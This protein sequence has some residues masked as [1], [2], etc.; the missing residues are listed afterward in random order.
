MAKVN[1]KFIK[2]MQQ[3]LDENDHKPGWKDE[4]PQELLYLLTE[5][6]EELRH[7]ILFQGADDIVRECADVANFAMMI[8]DV[9]LPSKNQH[10]IKTNR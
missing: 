7:A 9:I 4:D 6:V 5:E 2:A 3:K 8:A 1:Q 10:E